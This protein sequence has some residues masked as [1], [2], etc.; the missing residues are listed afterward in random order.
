MT[1]YL[2]GRLTLVWTLCVAVTFVSWWLG[3]R[4]E[5]ARLEVN[6]ALTVGIAAIAL[7]K[8][9]LVFWHFMEVR[10]APSWL[11]WNC[12]GWLAFVALVLFAL[13]RH[14]L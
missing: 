9:R 10:T 6:P 14:S 3:A 1:A 4:G 11:R 12:D 5:N 13:Y 7:V 8:I 2:R